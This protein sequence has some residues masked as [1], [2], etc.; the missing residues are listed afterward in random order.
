MQKLSRR[1][2]SEISV[3][4]ILRRRL[5]L[6]ADTRPFREGSGVVIPFVLRKPSNS[7]EG[8]VHADLELE[9]AR[10][11]EQA[12]DLALEIAA[13]KERRRANSASSR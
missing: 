3:T 8:R 9:N 1:S 11:R 12:V 2:A 4:H 5:G 10:L 6:K 7:E 13:L